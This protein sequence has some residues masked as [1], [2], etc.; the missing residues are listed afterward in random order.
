MHFIIQAK[1]S[2]GNVSERLTIRND[3]LI[4]TLCDLKETRHIWAKGKLRMS[5]LCAVIR[6]FIPAMNV[7]KVLFKHN[8]QQLL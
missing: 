3:G 2:K 8:M 4:F 5:K 6:A 7:Y 1:N